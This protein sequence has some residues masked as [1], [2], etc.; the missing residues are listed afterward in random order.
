[1][2][3][4]SNIFAPGA[5]PVHPTSSAISNDIRMSSSATQPPPQVVPSTNRGYPI[6]PSPTSTLPNSELASLLADANSQIQVLRSALNDAL[7]SSNFQSSQAAKF[8]IAQLEKHV[9]DAE[10]RCG[11]EIAHRLALTDQYNGLCQYLDH[12]E[13][14][15]GGARARM[16]G[17]FVSGPGPGNSAQSSR[18]RP[19]SDS[20]DAH[21]LPPP[22]R[23]R[24]ENPSSYYQHPIDPAYFETVNRAHLPHQMCIP[25]YATHPPPP[26]PPS[27]NQNHSSSRPFPSH[28]SASHMVPFPQHIV[29]HHQPV[30]YPQQMQTTSSNNNGPV[31]SLQSNHSTHSQNQFHHLNHSSQPHQ[32]SSD[33]RSRS[34]SHIL[35][36]SRSLSQSG[37][38]PEPMLVQATRIGGGK[39]CPPTQ[40]VPASAA[41]Y[42][43]HS[44]QPNPTISSSLPVPRSR[45]N[46]P[47]PARPVVVGSEHPSGP[48]P[49]P[50]LSSSSSSHRD[51][52]DQERDPTSEE[53]RDHNDT[54]RP[55]QHRPRPSPTNPLLNPDLPTQPQVK[56]EDDQIVFKF[57]GHRYKYKYP[58][59]A[60]DQRICLQ[61]KKIGSINKD[62]IC[63]EAWGPG[64]MGPG[65]FC[66]CCRE[67]VL[68]EEEKKNKQN[69]ALA[70]ALQQARRRRRRRQQQQLTLP[71]QGLS[72]QNSNR[73]VGLASAEAGGSKGH[74][75]PLKKVHWHLPPSPFTSPLFLSWSSGSRYSSSEGSPTR[76]SRNMDVDADD[77]LDDDDFDDELMNM[78]K[79]SPRVHAGVVFEDGDVE[80]DLLEAVE[81][82]E[83]NC[84]Q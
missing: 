76:S 71:M 14:T 18:T 51:P 16:D 78:V 10:I 25:P 45:S 12:V 79:M 53:G 17:F 30:T 74:S 61:C 15:S 34:S 46:I 67:K 39:D 37:K 2:P 11:Q 70:A 57:I 69:E 65:T 63:T 5:G 28:A 77:E 73:D 42:R 24:V 55:N 47:E 7:T 35:N 3:N 83:A 48:A 66:R 81:A 4:M 19:R 44:L 52:K 43:S 80:A 31:I 60:S 49:A 64:P 13:G 21:S 84:K 58:H 23:S 72:R 75:T 56:V 40:E 82:A 20:M 36:R 1:M 33:S 32:P 59:N 27:G 50:T 9:H 68:R 29:R 38:A 6:L 8:K 62:G 41:A 54:Q 22:K 26:L